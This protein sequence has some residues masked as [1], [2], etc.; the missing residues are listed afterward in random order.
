M[1][2]LA[3]TSPHG[4]M[5]SGENQKDKVVIGMEKRSKNFDLE[6]KAVWR[7]DTQEYQWRNSVKLEC[8]E[9]T[10]FSDMVNFLNKVK[11]IVSKVKKIYGQYGDS[12]T[13]KLI[14]TEYVYSHSPE[15]GGKMI[16][17]N[18]WVSENVGDNVGDIDEEGIYLRPDTRY[19]EETLDMYISYKNPLEGIISTIG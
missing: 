12:A 7:K 15:I 14:F 11:K 9:N 8:S 19:T 10:H 13:Y 5:Q 2:P 3:V 1:L 16:E 17:Y 18:R 4:K 6:V